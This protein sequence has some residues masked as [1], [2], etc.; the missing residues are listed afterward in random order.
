[1][2]KNWEYNGP[3]KIGLVTPIAGVFQWIGFND[4]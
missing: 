3:E 1:M 4:I 2:L